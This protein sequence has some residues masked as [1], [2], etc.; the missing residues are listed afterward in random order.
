MLSSIGHM[1]LGYTYLS[2]SVIVELLR[3]GGDST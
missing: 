2:T 1:L 3:S